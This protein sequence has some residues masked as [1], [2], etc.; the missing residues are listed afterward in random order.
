M[1]GLNTYGQMRDIT[2]IGY[3]NSELDAYVEAAALE[4]GRRVRPDPKPEKGSYFRSD[5]FPFAKEGIPTIYVSSGVDH[6]KYGEAWTLE[7]MDRFVAEKY[8]KPSEEYNPNWDLSGAIDDLRLL[9]KV[10]YRL[11][12]ESTFPNWREGTEYRAKRDVAMAASK[13]EKSP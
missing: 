2:V 7:K 10:G 3:G 1:D 9:F 11:A 4:Q 12:M 8:H 6:V 5:H 13:Q